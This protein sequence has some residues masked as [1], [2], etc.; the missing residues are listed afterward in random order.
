MSLMNRL[1]RGL[2]LGQRVAGHYIAIRKVK[3]HS[4]A[5]TLKSKKPGREIR[6]IK[7]EVQHS[8]ILQG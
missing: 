2:K 3:T 5:P 8:G 7:S 4:Q 1:N 6:I